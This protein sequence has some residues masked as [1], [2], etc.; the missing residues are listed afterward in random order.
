MYNNKEKA[1]MGEKL[2][3]TSLVIAAVCE[4]YHLMSEVFYP[5]SLRDEQLII[6]A[7]MQ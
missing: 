5:G 1:M 2:T 3:E 4:Y 7:L 6:I